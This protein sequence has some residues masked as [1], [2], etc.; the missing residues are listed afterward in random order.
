[1][2]AQAFGVTEDEL[3]TEDVFVGQFVALV[4]EIRHSRHAGLYPFSR[5]RDPVGC[6]TMVMASLTTR[7]EHR[8]CHTELRARR[9]RD[10]SQNPCTGHFR[11][12]LSGFR[13]YKP[14]KGRWLLGRDLSEEASTPNLYC[15]R[16][17]DSVFE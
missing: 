4:F 1:M 10:V 8:R 12:A 5:C 7:S 2:E 14:S 9:R 16:E 11:A 17:I 13:Y 3:D 15:G 6:R